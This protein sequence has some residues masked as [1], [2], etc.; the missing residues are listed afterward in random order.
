MEELELK[1]EEFCES[2]EL[3]CKGWCHD[4]YELRCKGWCHDSEN[5]RY[6]I[7]LPATES[8]N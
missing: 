8:F 7:R 6:S 4:R 5:S 2:S 3:R 1:A